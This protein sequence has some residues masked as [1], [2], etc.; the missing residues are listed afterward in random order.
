MRRQ[1]NEN[2]Q[3]YWTIRSNGRLYTYT[4][5]STLSPADVWCDISHLHQKDPERTGYA[6]QKPEALLER[7]ILVSSEEKDIVLDC[8]CGSGV[9]PAVAERLDRRWL[10]CDQSEVAINVTSERLRKAQKQHPFALQYV[11]TIE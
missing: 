11:T 9:T 10:A 7:I 5:D 8:C 6:T 4:E 2:G 1:V 3:V